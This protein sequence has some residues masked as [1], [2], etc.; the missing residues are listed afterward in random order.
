MKKKY[1]F[2]L[3]AACVLC[4]GFIIGMIV[5]SFRSA[6]KA[7]PVEADTGAY[8]QRFARICKLLS[9]NTLAVSDLADAVSKSWIKAIALGLDSTKQVEQVFAELEQSGIRPRLAQAHQELQAQMQALQDVPFSFRTSFTVL[10]QTYAAY[11]EL[12]KLSLNP[13]GSLVIFNKKVQEL[14]QELAKDFN[15]LN[16]YTPKTVVEDQRQA[17]EQLRVLA[18]Q[19]PALTAEDTGLIVGRTE[20]QVQDVFGAPV[21]EERAAITGFTLRQ[22]SYKG[23]DITVYFKNDIVSGWNE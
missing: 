2:S 8:A 11:A 16:L 17:G 20:E 15:R 22:Y 18:S 19:G 3:V 13:S 1:L 10:E 5:Q 7:Q 9:V 6:N 4:A 14:Q 12:Y 21:Y 23:R